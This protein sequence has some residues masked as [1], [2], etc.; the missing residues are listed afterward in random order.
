MNQAVAEA[1]HPGKPVWQPC[2][3]RAC[4]Q[5]RRR[6]RSA[7]RRRRNAGRDDHRQA[8]PRD[9]IAAMDRILQACARPTLAEA[10]LYSDLARPA[11]K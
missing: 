10:A 3:G 9:Q 5:C 8:L 11:A 1:Q 7:A 4:N 2:S 6:E